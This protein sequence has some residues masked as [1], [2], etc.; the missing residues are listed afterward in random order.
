VELADS[1][2]LRGGVLTFD[3][4]YHDQGPDAMGSYHAALDDLAMQDYDFYMFCGLC[5]MT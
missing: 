1:R 2:P 3:D 5:W 4:S